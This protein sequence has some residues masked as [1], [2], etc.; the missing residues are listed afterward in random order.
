[1]KIQN[2]DLRS[3][4]LFTAP[5]LSLKLF[6]PIKDTTSCEFPPLELAV[7]LSLVALLFCMALVEKDG[8]DD[9][10]DDDNDDDDDRVRFL[11]ND[12]SRMEHDNGAD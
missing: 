2:S 3:R 12:F 10:D 1:M 8:V 5:G 4:T 6:N 7:L 9:D 11:R